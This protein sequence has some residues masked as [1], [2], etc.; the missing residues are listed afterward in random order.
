MIPLL[1]QGDNAIRN[2]AVQSDNGAVQSEDGAVQFEDVMADLSTAAGLEWRL[3]VDLEWMVSISLSGHHQE[4]CPR[5]R[6]RGR[7]GVV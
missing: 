1:S 3:R 7:G 4:L 6:G 2:G 5:T